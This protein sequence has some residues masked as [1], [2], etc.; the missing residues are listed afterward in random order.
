[1]GQV[2][3]DRDT[4]VPRALSTL[5]QA[6][7]VLVRATDEGTLLQ[8]MCT[9]I[10]D[11][12]GYLLCWYGRPVDDDVRSV[13]PVARAG[14]R[15]DYVDDI[16]ISWDD[17]PLGQ[18]PTGRCIRTRQTQVVN[19]F[20]PDSTYGPW[21]T[22]AAQRGFSCSICLP[23]IVGDDLDGVLMVYAA[24][25]GSFGS[26]ATSLLEDLAA[27]LGYG[28]SRLRD[29]ADLERSTQESQDHRD[30]MHATIDSLIDPFILLEA[31]RDADGRLVDLRYLEAN[32]AALAYNRISREDLIGACMFDLFPGQV[33]DGTAAKYLHTVDTGEPTVLDDYAYG[34]ERVGEERRYDIR[35]IR[36]GDGIALTWRD[37]TERSAAA[38]RLADSERMYRLLAENST[39]VIL[40][41]DADRTITWAS[42]STGTTL[43][44]DRDDLL[45]HQ[46][47]DFIDPDDRPRLA[48]LVAESNRTMT[49]L[50]T[51]IRWCRPDGTHHWMRATGRPFV[52]DDSGA[53]RR[54]VNLQAIDEQVQGENELAEREERYRLLAE[55]VSDIVLQVDPDGSIAWASSSTK[56][57][58][59]REPDDLL[60][61]LAVDLIHPDDAERALRARAAV[62]TGETDE[63]EFRVLRQDGT[64]LWM[65]I[66]VRAVPT[67][68]GIGRVVAARNIDDEVLSRRQ[69]EFALEHD[70]LT[71]LPTRRAILDR[72][73][74]LQSQLT[75]D[76][77]VAV[78][79]IDIDDLASI[80]EALAYA[81]GDDVLR[82]VATRIH[83]AAPEPELVGRGAGDE[84]LVVVAST[85]AGDDTDVLSLA[86]EIRADASTAITVNGHDIVVTVSI[87]IAVGDPET[88]G[89]HLLHEANLAASL[90]KQKG[91]NRCDFVDREVAAQAEKRLSLEAGI[92]DGLGRGQF[93]PWFQPI[94]AIDTGEV[95]GYEALVRWVRPDGVVEPGGFLPVAE[96]TSLVTDLDVAVLRQSVA[97][98]A[99]LPAPLTVAVNVAAA[100]LD[101][102]AYADLVIEIL[103]ETGADPKRL[104]LEVTETMLLDLTTTVPA[105]MRRLADLGV[106]WYVDDFGTGYSSI[107]HLRDLPIAGLK[108]D[109][110]FTS[111]IGAGDRTSMRLA[112]ALIG[113]ARGLGLDTVAE[114]VE[115]QAEADYLRT[116]GWRH[117]QGWLYGRAAP[118][119]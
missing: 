74:G 63:R 40:V 76:A 116:L 42:T 98:L 21:Q 27:D 77:Q 34:N 64:T 99:T 94:V 29:M 58:L 85:G 81:A 71:R 112:D 39:D 90:A 62:L 2:V 80:N 96:R 7:R 15:Q 1:M 86:E 106:R 4:S 18:G 47:T 73:E 108:L 92:R 50:E 100:T 52:D 12:G 103:A 78:L 115:T 20:A 91:G 89:E 97:E 72:I 30:R 113:L 82:T 49:V 69:L 79:C 23:V 24:E 48:A 43:G 25:V 105:A 33:A 56:R 28:L 87:G 45:D 9:T 55:N 6:N 67:A 117:G 66:D 75:A 61:T 32:E 109:R 84:I 60:G 102:M 114:G 26:M 68:H 119:A 118:L 35:A 13:Q 46:A 57:M 95:S 53:L 31:V 44:W 5:S 36:S 107:S 54:V 19:D 10:A 70:Q 111:A 88:D 104:H 93:V 110:S 41:T 101:R 16:R 22:A 8:Q 65:A 3:P 38:Q 51:R 59:G 17:G 83:A 11:T 37:V 14:T